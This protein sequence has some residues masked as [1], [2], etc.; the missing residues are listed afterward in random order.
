MK[1]FNSL[2]HIQRLI[3]DIGHTKCTYCLGSGKK[4]VYGNSDIPQRVNCH[5]CK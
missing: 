1:M 2:L 5:K 3:K 4:Y